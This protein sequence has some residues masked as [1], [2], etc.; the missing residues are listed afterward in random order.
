MQPVK[1]LTINDAGRDRRILDQHHLLLTN[2][3]QTAICA[4][5]LAELLP[6]RPGRC[7]AAELA[8]R[9]AG[10]AERCMDWSTAAPGTCDHEVNA[11]ICRQARAAAKRARAAN[12]E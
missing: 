5:R 7:R 8:D 3:A 6:D 2:L 12:R 10:S 9:A 1:F 4:A 11:R